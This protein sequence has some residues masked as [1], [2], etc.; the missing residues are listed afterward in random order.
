MGSLLSGNQVSGF[1]KYEN[2]KNCQ[3]KVRKSNYFGIFIR[4]KEFF[5][6]D[7]RQVRSKDLRTTGNVNE[8]DFIM[9]IM[10]IMKSFSGME[11]LLLQGSMPDVLLS[12]GL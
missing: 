1:G 2:T 6:K 7:S 3:L 4:E 5:F 9:N 12:P 10:C 11:I 8:Y